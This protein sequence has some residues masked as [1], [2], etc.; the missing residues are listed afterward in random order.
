MALSHNTAAEYICRKS[1]WTVTQLALQKI[2]YLAHM[3][4]LG[5]GNGP[6]VSGNFEAWDYGPVH[7]ALYQ[8]VKAFGAKPIPNVFWSTEPVFGSHKEILDE[9]CDNLLGQSPGSLVQNTHRPDGAWALHYS[10]IARNI[11][12]PT[13]AIIDEYK[14]RVGADEAA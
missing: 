2:L 6:L 11:V 12:I 9:A 5:R 4:H 10:P 8:K 1:G 14:K 13:S 7:P 3:V